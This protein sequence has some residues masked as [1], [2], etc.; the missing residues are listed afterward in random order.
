MARAIID[1]LARGG[2][3]LAV[4][5]PGSRSTALTLAADEHPGIETVVAL[6]ERSGGFHAL[7]RAK[8]Q[9]RP[10]AAICTSGTA[11]ANY[12]PAVV[13]ADMSLTPL[14]AL[15]ADRPAELRG[16][17]ANQTIDQ[18]DL[19]GGSVRFFADIAAPEV[20]ASLNDEWRRA[21]SQAVS[22][23]LG[24]GGRPGP[25]H[26]NVA[27]RE[28]TV[29]APDDGRAVSPPYVHGIDG[30][31]DG[32][33]WTTDLIAGPP[34]AAVDA[35]SAP[36]GLV[37]AGEGEYDRER[38]TAEARLLGWP[39]LATAQSG[40]RGGDVIGAYHHI[41]AGGVPERLRPEA[42]AAVGAI[43]P[44]PRLQGLFAAAEHRVSID[45]WGRRLDPG[46]NATAVVHGE[47]GRVLASVDGSPSEE[48]A[49]LWRA[50]DATVGEAIEAVVAGARHW[51]GAGAVR[52]LNMV[53]WDRLVAASSLPIR[54]VDAHLRRPGRVIANRGAS[55]IDGFV[56]TALGAAAPGEAT[57]AL[58]G[59]LS[60]LHDSN[61][62]LTDASRDLVI[63]VLDNGGGGLFD[64]LPQ[65]RLAPSYERLFVA[66]H[67]RDLAR[68]ADFHGV[69]LTD[70]GN[71]DELAAEASLRLGRGGAHLLRAA[72]DRGRDIEARRSL[73]AAALQALSVS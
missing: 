52:A 19:Y 33:R 2:V 3:G 36:R 62:L 64:S 58:S 40:M 56:S 30:R 8:A 1:E 34:E 28:P 35:L 25:V 69:E 26:L 10:A 46:R 54:E 32:A 39:V 15:T 14:V 47:P 11:A 73:D 37:I 27:F 42:V 68:L 5:S 21:A 50:A 65:A 72:V 22:A 59:D 43:G 12:H 31:A 29:P 17:G 55:G 4:I 63:V 13:E 48:W 51:T 41:L 70:V 61:G 24:A 57:A 38:L 23:A 60:L 16:V 71:P 53:S 66:P 20:G 45:R 67:G 9:G 49:A 44:S 7:G 6:D 18:V